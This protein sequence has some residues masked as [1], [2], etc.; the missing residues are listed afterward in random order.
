MLSAIT[1]LPFGEAGQAPRS[2]GLGARRPVPACSDSRRKAAD[3]HGSHCSNRKCRRKRDCTR[4]VR[5]L[6]ELL[7]LV[8]PL[9][10]GIMAPLVMPFATAAWLVALR[11]YDRAPALP[12]IE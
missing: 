6:L 11:A 7:L 3:P 8:G 12:K 9:L 5:A 2:A 1:G 10:V 4:S